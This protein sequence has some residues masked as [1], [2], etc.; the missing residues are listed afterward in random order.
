VKILLKRIAMP[1]AVAI[2]STLKELADTPDYIPDFPSAVD[3]IFKE[4]A[5]PFQGDKPLVET[6]VVMT[7]SPVSALDS[8]VMTELGKGTRHDRIIHMDD[9]KSE[10]AF[11]EIVLDYLL[12]G[13]VVGNGKENEDE[14]KGS[15][16]DSS[17]LVIQV[18]PLQNSSLQIN[19]AKFI[20]S[21]LL[22]KYEKEILAINERKAL[23]FLIHLPPAS[24][25]KARHFVLDFHSPWQYWFVDDVRGFGKLSLQHKPVNIIDILLAPIHDL[26]N[27]GF[28]DLKATIKD[29]LGPAIC[30]ARLPA[31]ATPYQLP[32]LNSKSSVSARVS[33][34]KADSLLSFSYRSRL[35]GSRSK[36]LSSK[37]CL[38]R[39]SG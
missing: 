17:I 14:G 10:K 26:F 3:L 4:S 25:D 22:S 15:A 16:V 32:F 33:A 6:A 37:S 8:R 28:L 9:I 34:N 5:I 1:A 7:Q 27:N 35:C 21:D 20:C 36:S 30:R 39:W 31:Y 29:H 11:A 24:R 23:I 19:H 12:R 13:N 18:D 2:S 38:L